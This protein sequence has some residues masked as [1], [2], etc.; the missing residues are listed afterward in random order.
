[1]LE[2]RLMQRREALDASKADMGEPEP[3]G[4]LDC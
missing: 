1:M 2:T 3:V 4:L